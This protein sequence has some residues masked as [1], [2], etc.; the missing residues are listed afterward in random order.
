[1]AQTVA[2][3]NT[4]GLWCT[5]PGPN[6]TER[7]VRDD[8]LRKGNRHTSAAEGPLDLARIQLA[9]R[10]LADRLSPS[11]CWMVEDGV[12]RAG[13]LF[14]KAESLMPTGSFKIRGATFKL[15]TLTPAERRRGVIAYSTGN[16]AQAV[17]KAARDETIAATIIMSPD[18][19]AAKIEATQRWGAQVV[20]AEASSH[21]RRAM[22]ERLARE[23]GLVIVPP[24]DDVDVMAGQG[25]I[26]LEL[27]EQMQ[28]DAA[29]TVYVPIGGGGLLAGVATAIKQS[30]R[31]VR[32]VGVEPELEND[33]YLSFRS[34]RLVSL[35]GPSS[36]VADAIKV[37]QLGTLTFPV[38]NRYVDEIELVSEAEIVQATFACWSSLKLV[39]EPGGAVAMA[40]AMRATAIDGGIAVALLCGGNVSPEH[41]MQIQAIN[42]SGG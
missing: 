2:K 20:M 16:H 27:L 36:S 9:R 40:A 15:S 24:Y 37:Q 31:S 10:V 23:K 19:P 17:A 11:P 42:Q 18:V 34:G 29:F 14:V 7:S 22:A 39:I 5:T 6:A 26:G 8:V 12:T 21:A 38:I 25:T 41:F 30:V 28:V 33:A 35:S 3:S 4:E 13:R 32:V 1:V